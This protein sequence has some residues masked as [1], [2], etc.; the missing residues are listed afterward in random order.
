MLPQ[1]FYLLKHLSLPYLVILK[2][3]C[4]NIIST[5]IMSLYALYV[6]LHILSLTRI[7]RLILRQQTPHF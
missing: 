2:Q 3:S 6:C 1:M 7:P 5:L 4:N